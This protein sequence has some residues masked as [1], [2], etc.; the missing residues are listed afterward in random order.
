MSAATGEASVAAHR[1]PI[2]L[3][4]GSPRRKL[5]LEQAGYDVRVSA[6][7]VDDAHLSRPTVSP[8][9]WVMSLAYLKARATAFMLQRT[10]QPMDGII[11]AA[12]TMCV[13]DDIAL[14]QPRDADD[15][16]RMLRSM[17]DREHVTMTG[18]CL[19]D[20]GDQRRLLEVDEATVRVGAVS[21]A[22][23]HA[24]LESGRWQGKAG[25]YNLAE[26]IDAG[27]PIEC[28]G[29]PATVMGLPMKALPKWIDAFQGR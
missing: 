26:R 5:L 4:S 21:D 8:R 22:Q 9:W 25:A 11:V 27:W 24:Y 6:P 20:A 7:P 28:I 15:A 29:D 19:F 12:D 16:R 17:R 18:V 23:M 10:G 13:V 3:A 1:G 2:I 14:G